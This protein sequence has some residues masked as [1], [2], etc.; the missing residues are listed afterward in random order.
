MSR[1]VMTWIRTAT[2]TPLNSSSAM[3]RLRSASD[4]VNST[5]ATA[6]RNTTDMTIRV[7]R[8]MSVM[9]VPW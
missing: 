3:N 9:A 7:P 2:V 5:H 6:M 4:R 8:R 1:L